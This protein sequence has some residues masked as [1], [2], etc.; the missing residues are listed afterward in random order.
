MPRYVYNCLTCDSLEERQRSVADRDN[1]TVCPGCGQ[2]MAR[3]LNA[4][5]IRF[6]GD[7]WQT[8]R[9]VRE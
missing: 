3:V 7:G 2:F 9:P 8:P 5:T 1:P 4:P 6:T